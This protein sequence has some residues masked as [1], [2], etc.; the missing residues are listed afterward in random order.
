[1]KPKYSK[2]TLHVFLPVEPHLWTRG[3]DAQF[4]SDF[5]TAASDPVPSEKIPP[6]E[7]RSKC[8]S[9]KRTLA[10]GNFARTS[11]SFLR[12]VWTFSADEKDFSQR[13][14]LS[15]RPFSPV[16]D[17]PHWEQ[18][19]FAFPGSDKFVANYFAM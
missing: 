15:V 16:T 10:A 3:L 4:S 17:P 1:M 2:Y 14:N 5:G 9:V 7:H 19:Q 11:S 6:V 8:S 12:G 18:I 13:F